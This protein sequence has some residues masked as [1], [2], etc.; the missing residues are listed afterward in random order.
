[1][2][3]SPGRFDPEDLR[4]GLALEFLSTTADLHVHGNIQEKPDGKL[5]IKIRDYESSYTVSVSKDY[6]AGLT[7][8]QKSEWIKG[9]A[10]Q[11]QTMHASG[12]TSGFYDPNRRSIAIHGK[13][14]FFSTQEHIQTLRQEYQKTREDLIQAAKENADTANELAT[15]RQSNLTNDELETLKSARKK[16]ILRLTELRTEIH[17]L[18]QIHLIA[19]QLFIKGG[20]ATELA[21]D[22]IQVNESDQIHTVPKLP[23]MGTLPNPDETTI[24]SSTLPSP[25]SSYLREEDLPEQNGREAIVATGRH[26]VP[27]DGLSSKVA[28]ILHMI[29]EGF[30]LNEAAGGLF[31]TLSELRDLQLTPLE[32]QALSKGL[33]EIRSTT[34]GENVSL[35]DNFTKSVLDPL[36]GQ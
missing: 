22:A 21:P 36:T 2:T 16:A 17:R 33:Q 3:I 26:F 29:R 30:E 24:T 28:A 13:A 15:Y 27:P 14:F 34:K 20:I 23:P 5:S 31:P 6:I 9:L 25:P 4:R 12:S 7:D 8:K 19:G 10:V 18:D 11:L 35:I 32:L 1:M